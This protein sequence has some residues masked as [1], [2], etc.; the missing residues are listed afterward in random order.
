MIA[1]AM[2]YIEIIDILSITAIWFLSRTIVLKIIHIITNMLFG[3]SYRVGTYGR[4]ERSLFLTGFLE[5]FVCGCA[6]GYII[7]RRNEKFVNKK[8]LTLGLLVSFSGMLTDKILAMLFGG[9]HMISVMVYGMVSGTLYIFILYWLT[10]NLKYIKD[11][12]GDISD[13]VNK[14]LNN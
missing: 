10:G 13:G 11:M 3:V 8:I 7:K 1:Y 14:F 4:I 2:K 9:S 5:E 6:I 12:A